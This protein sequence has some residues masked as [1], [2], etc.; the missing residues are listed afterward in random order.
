MSLAAITPDWTTLSP[1]LDEALDQPADQ[2][3]AWL[4]A[5]GPRASAAQREALGRL[6]ALQPSVEVGGFLV[7][8]P[9]LP[10]GISSAVAGALVGPYRLM[11]EIGHG[12]MSTVWRAERADFAPRREVALKLPLLTWGG[13]FAERLARERDIVAALEHPNIARFLDAGL[14]D[15]GR[16]WLATELIEGEPIDAYCTRHHLDLRERLGLVLQ[17]CDA[18]AHA[19]AR[20][21]IHRDLKPANILVTPEGT[22]KLL[23]FGIAKLLQGQ[24]AAETALTR[25]AGRALTPDFASPE[26]IRGEPLS[27]ASDV[28]AIGV[29]AYLLVTGERP[30][31]LRRGSV[32]ELEE[33]ITQ[34]QPQRA[35][36]AAREAGVRRQLRGDLDAILAKALRKD[37]ASR[38]VGAGEMAQDVRRHLAGLPIEARPQGRM[39]RMQHF[40]RRHKAAVGM[41]AVVLGA[42][43]TGLGAATWQ[44]AVAR[45]QE[46]IAH[47]AVERERAVQDMLVEILSVAVTADPARLKEPG[48]FGMLLEEKF[49]QLERRF[50]DRPDEWLDLLEVISTRLPEHGDFVCSYAV[51]QRYVALL[52][53]THADE[54]R[55][56][57]AT[58]MNARA[59]DHLNYRAKAATVLRE[60]LRT[61]SHRPETAPLRKDMTE[62]L[63]AWGG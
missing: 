26:Q 17:V 21:V 32:A 22:V 5:L 56:A 54:L 7:Q 10:A 58:L 63:A 3:P 25:A 9:A 11:E 14:D 43:G 39:E 29:V 27:T 34:T 6:L 13:R 41:L 53:A 19:H 49:E 30:Y 28:Y 46:R 12:G 20:L 45:Q 16:P 50:H 40:V 8:V 37:V 2:R 44:A 55:I 61:L 35:S 36:D 51:G 42:L 33:A 60:A 4:A 59:L 31:R 15:A 24:H 18:V 23:D 52:R 1:L 62:A 38:Y 57:R 47:K 48:G